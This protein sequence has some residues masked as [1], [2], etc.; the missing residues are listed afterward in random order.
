MPNDIIIIPS[1]NTIQFTNDFVTSNLSQESSGD[2][3]IDTYFLVNNVEIFGYF[4]TIGPISDVYTLSSVDTQRY[5]IFDYT[6][7]VYITLTTDEDG[8]WTDSNE[9]MLQQ[10]GSGKI[11]IS[12]SSGVTVNSIKSIKESKNMNSILILKRVGS[13]VWTLFGDLN[14]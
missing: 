6:S 5:L 2:L 11:I 14:V 7:D 9:I 12:P 1:G 10:G 3:Y 13:N 8:G 4:P